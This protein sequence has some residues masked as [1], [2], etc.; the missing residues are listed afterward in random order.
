V[1][2]LAGTGRGLSK[3]IRREREERGYGTACKEGKKEIRKIKMP[4]LFQI[5]FGT[6]VI[7]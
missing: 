6:D 4:S 2:G 7:S 1:S 3:G 5:F